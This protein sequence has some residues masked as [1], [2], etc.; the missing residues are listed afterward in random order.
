MQFEGTMA[1]IHQGGGQPPQNQQRSM[2]SEQPPSYARD[3][4]DSHGLKVISERIKRDE[5]AMKSLQNYFQVC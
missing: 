4:W 1:T 2:I 3:L 5:K